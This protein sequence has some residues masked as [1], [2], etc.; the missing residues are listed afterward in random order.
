MVNQFDHL[1]NII[2][3]NINGNGVK[4]YVRKFQYEVNNYAHGASW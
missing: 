2:A 4:N 3:S 1:N